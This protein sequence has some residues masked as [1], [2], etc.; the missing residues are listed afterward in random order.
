MWV[1]CATCGRRHFGPY[2]AAGLVLRD[3]AGRLLLTHRSE[4]VH[5]PGTWS[6]PGGAL[7]DGET[8][9]DAALREV[10]EELGL[11]VDA[12]LLGTT[13]TGLDHD[14]WRYTYVL[15]EMHP[16][17]TDPRLELNWEADAVA[18]VAPDGMAELAL[19]PD[20]RADLPALLAALAQP[21]R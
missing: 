8:P 16:Q 5:Y 3:G 19:H 10:G 12:V 9:V 15:G 18:W 4:L 11:P 14:T 1:T 17:W 20:L 6:F 2:G 13:L 7:A 21:A